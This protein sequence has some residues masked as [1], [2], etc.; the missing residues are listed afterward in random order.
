MPRRCG[1][2]HGASA[3]RSGQDGRHQAHRLGKLADPVG[4]VRGI[5]DQ[6]LAHGLRH[7]GEDGLFRLAGEGDLATAND[8]RGLALA[9]V[10]LRTQLLKVF[11]EPL[12]PEG[13]PA[14]GA[15]DVGDFEAGI[16]VEDA[17]ADHVHEGNH[18]LEGEGR[19]VHVAILLHALG[20]GAHGAPDAVLAVVAGLRIDG[21]R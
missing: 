14:A 5:H 15:L 19:H 6:V 17:L 16:A 18:G 3:R 11:V 13:Q 12:R 8:L 10:P 4:V 21:E 7:V 20:A 2:G 9:E 1:R